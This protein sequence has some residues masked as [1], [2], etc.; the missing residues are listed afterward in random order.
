MKNFILLLCL[1]LCFAACKNSSQKILDQFEANF[2]QEEKKLDT[3]FDAY[4][5]RASNL[6]INLNKKNFYE[7][8][9]KILDEVQPADLSEEGQEQLNF[10][11]SLVN[12]KLQAVSIK[13]KQLQNPKFYELLPFFESNFNASQLAAPSQ[14]S[15]FQRELAMVPHFFEQAKSNIQQPNLKDIQQAVLQQTKF[16]SFLRDEMRQLIDGLD[17][18]EQQKKLH[19]LTDDG[20][21]AVKDFVAYCRSLQFEIRDSKLKAERPENID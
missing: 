6:S 3:D 18:K 20:I 16:F 4:L 21:I 5:E 1:A 14:L 13:I 8:Q 2:E 17:N 19:L 10:S 7:E 11:K 12:E 15:F 9:S